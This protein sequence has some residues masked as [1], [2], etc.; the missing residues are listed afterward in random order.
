MCNHYFFLASQYLYDRNSRQTQ[1]SHFVGHE[2]DIVEEPEQ[3]VE[4]VDKRLEKARQRLDSL[5]IES[6]VA[7]L[8]V[9]EEIRLKHCLDT[10]RDVCGESVTDNQMKA[11]IIQANFN[12]ERALDNILNGVELDPTAVLRM[13]NFLSFDLLELDQTI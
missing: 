11:H 13:S 1:L 5:S 10:I 3:E 6:A 2:N 12:P 7:K 8:G 4:T 9:D